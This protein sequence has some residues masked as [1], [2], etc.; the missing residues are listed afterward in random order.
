[1][2]PEKEMTMR[3]YWNMISGDHREKLVSLAQKGKL[4]PDQAM[5]KIIQHLLTGNPNAIGPK[6]LKAF[7]TASHI[8]RMIDT[9]LL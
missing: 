8:E 7:V 5:G 2:H 9:L 3:E 6:Y 4:E 1:M